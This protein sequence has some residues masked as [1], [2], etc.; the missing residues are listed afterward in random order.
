M[1]VL[2]S[3]QNESKVLFV[4]NAR[5]LS[6]MTDNEI[7]NHIPRRKRS[8]FGQRAL[9]SS[10]EIY[11]LV[12]KA[13]TKDR[14]NKKELTERIELLIE[15]SEEI[16]VYERLVTLIC[17]SCEIPYSSMLEW[18]ELI[19]TEIRLINGT[20]RSDKQKYKQL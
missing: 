7:V 17:A 13:N 9:D 18:S 1:S 11:R 20:I 14:E 2:K 15:A 10:I 4:F 6:L 3:L 5:K 19:E 8:G 16:K 12:E